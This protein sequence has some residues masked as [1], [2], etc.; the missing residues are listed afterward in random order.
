MDQK[1]AICNC[2][3]NSEHNKLT[4]WLQKQFWQRI[5]PKLVSW[6]IFNPIT[7]K[8][9]PSNRYIVSFLKPYIESIENS[10]FEIIDELVEFYVSLVT[11][12]ELESISG[13]YCYQTYVVDTY[14]NFR[15]TI[16]CQT[17]A[18]SNGMIHPQFEPLDSDPG[19]HGVI[20]NKSVLEL[21]SGTGLLG[22]IC[23]LIGATEVLLTD[24]HRDVLAL[25]NHNAKINSANA[26]NVSVRMLDWSQHSLVDDLRGKYDVILGSDLVYDPDTNFD[27]VKLLES[28]IN[29]KS[30]MAYI[31]ST[32]RNE[33]TFDGFIKFLES[34]P[35]LESSTMDISD[36]SQI[37][38]RED[39]N[40]II[41]LSII[42]LKQ[43]SLKQQTPEESFK[44]ITQPLRTA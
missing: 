41:K 32:V 24:T 17:S 12:V 27:L 11:I 13:G 28:L 1:C 14:N 10:E 30:Q 19:M 36:I 2:G 31:A 7:V 6:I 8:F 38:L 43:P 21:G 34:S 20:A 18:I 3:T 39:Q 29:N 44:E 9:S 26:K 33:D 22:I 40:S 16:K 5:P 42:A 25:L 35:V 23:S 37:L 4:E 15:A